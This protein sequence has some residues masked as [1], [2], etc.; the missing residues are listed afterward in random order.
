MSPLLLTRPRFKIARRLSF[1]RCGA[2]AA[3]PNAELPRQA[4]SC[5]FPL[6]L[7]SGGVCAC[8][9]ART[10]ML[11]CCMPT[12]SCWIFFFFSPKFHN[13]LT[14]HSTN[15]TS[16]FPCR[17]CG[18]ATSAASV[19]V[20]CVCGQAGT[21]RSLA[22]WVLDQ[23]PA[24]EHPS[25]LKAAQGSKVALIKRQPAAWFTQPSPKC[26]VTPAKVFFGK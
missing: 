24:G 11:T 9:H 18:S 2:N 13:V 22:L 12:M 3:T 19:C 4:K 7:H 21:H 5:I 6:S 25:P 23:Q 14:C 26:R 20:C 1:S 8:V 15:P 10:H 16:H 17:T